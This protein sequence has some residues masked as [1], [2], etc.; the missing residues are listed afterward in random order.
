MR[1]I[2][3]ALIALI[4]PFCLF[5]QTT[6]FFEDFEGTGDEVYISDTNGLTGAP[7][8]DYQNSIAGGGRLRMN[9]GVG[10][11]RS[12]T[13]AATMDRVPSGVN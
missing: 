3:F 13:K 9:A 1:S 12:G 6:I 2:Y 7:Q 4:F 11:A 8:W 10:F 5:A